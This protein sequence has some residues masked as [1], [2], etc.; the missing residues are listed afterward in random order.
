LM[1][2]L[3]CCL[4][5]VTSG[6]RRPLP[7]PGLTRGQRPRDW[8]CFTTSGHTGGTHWRCRWARGTAWRRRDAQAELWRRA[9]GHWLGAWARRAHGSARH[10][11][12]LGAAPTRRRRARAV[13]WLGAHHLTVS[14]A[15]ALRRRWRGDAHRY[16]PPSHAAGDEG[17]HRVDRGA[18]PPLARAVVSAA[19]DGSAASSGEGRLGLGHRIRLS[20][21]AVTPTAASEGSQYALLVGVAARDLHRPRRHVRKNHLT[22]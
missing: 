3:A 13:E 7:R 4:Q 19:V 14:C 5:G 9:G 1:F 16:A 15:V 8:G 2:F 17:A 21:A 12:Q 11:P 10:H 22:K 20:Q 18:R 6:Q